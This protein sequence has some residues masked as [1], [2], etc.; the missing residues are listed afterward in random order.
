MNA[1][2]ASARVAAALILAG[3]AVGL[4]RRL[5]HRGGAAP[6]RLAHCPIHGIAY[7]TD[8]EICPGCAKPGAAGG[9]GK[10]GVR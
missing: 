2:Q 7:D 5:G 8:L 10:G 1:H 9:T 6:L 3:A 4:G